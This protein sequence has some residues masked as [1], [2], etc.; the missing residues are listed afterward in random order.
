MPYAT[1]VIHMAM[2]Y[3][4]FAATTVT[5]VD[6]HLCIVGFK[7]LPNGDNVSARFGATGPTRN[8]VLLLGSVVVP[9]ILK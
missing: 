6:H 2:V 9:Q 3:L 1:H 7:G 4:S 5:G 8:A